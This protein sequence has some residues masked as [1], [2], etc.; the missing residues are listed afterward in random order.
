M[1]FIA[2]QKPKPVT[3]VY[4]R[5]RLVTDYFSGCCLCQSGLNVLFRHNW[6]P[7]GKMRSHAT[8]QEKTL[9]QSS[10]LTEP[11]WIDPGLKSGISMHGLNSTLKKKKKRAQAG[12][13]ST[14]LPPQ[15]L[16]ARKKPQPPPL[17]TL[18]STI[19]PFP[20]PSVCVY[21]YIYILWRLGVVECFLLCGMVCHRHNL[22][23]F[24]FFEHSL[25]EW[26]SQ[27]ERFWFTKPLL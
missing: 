14:N 5:Y 15:S 18:L 20:I 11:L 3:V 10:R 9:P 4:Y 25:V 8:R 23:E 13:E 21:I 7:S 19:N 1:K 27:N 6:G 12:N 2:R 24:R 16:Q 17:V 26:R 22:R